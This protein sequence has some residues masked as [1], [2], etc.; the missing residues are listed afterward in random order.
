VYWKDGVMNALPLGGATN[1]G[2]FAITEDSAGNIYVAGGTSTSPVGY[3]KNSTFVPLSLGTYAQGFVASIAVDT[4]GNVWLGGQVGTPN[5]NI[6]AYWENT[7]GPTV[8]PGGP[9][10]GWD[11]N[12]DKAGNVYFLG[13][14]NVSGNDIPYVWKNGAS[15]TALPLSAS[16]THGYPGT[17]TV[18]SSGN[19]YVIGQQYGGGAS[20][21]VYWKNIGGGWQNP[22]AFNPGTYFASGSWYAGVIGGAI[23]SSGNL[24]SAMSYGV[25]TPSSVVDWSSTSVAPVA[26]T[27][28]NGT[29]LV[30]VASGS[31]AL[32]D[33]GNLYAAGQAGNTLSSGNGSQLSD[34]VPAYWKNGT[35]SA[36]P[37]GTGNTWGMGGWVVV[38]K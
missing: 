12:A 31:V 11:L 27:I 17:L 4:T 32:D 22:V 7:G 24:H 26:G 3:W 15:Q 1:G 23:D 37:M 6:F 30:W 38:G 21:N 20:V 35:A 16:Y 36:L 2:A 33:S 13:T 19:L 18:D 10:N 9:D 14:I 29:T 25:P 8:L 5:P 34:G 28:P